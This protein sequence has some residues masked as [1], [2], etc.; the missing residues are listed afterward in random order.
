MTP[1]KASEKCNTWAEKW[2]EALNRD[3]VVKIEVPGSRSQ[4][5]LKATPQEQVVRWGKSA[6]YY[7]TAPS[8]PPECDTVEIETRHI[9]PPDTIEKVVTVTE[10]KDPPEGILDKID[11]IPP[12]IALAVPISLLLIYLTFRRIT[13]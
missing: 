9:T 11:N 13:K 1:Q 2:P 7:N 6:F 12:L 8:A 4:A 10:F 5:T 3:T